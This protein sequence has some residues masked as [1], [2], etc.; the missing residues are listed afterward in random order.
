M[1]FVKEGN[2]PDLPRYEKISHKLVLFGHV[3]DLKRSIFQLFDD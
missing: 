1:V 2:D 3:Y